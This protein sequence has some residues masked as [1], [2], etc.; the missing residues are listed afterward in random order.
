MNE[1][2]HF[3]IGCNERCAPEDTLCPRCEAALEI[4]DAQTTPQARL[5]PGGTI[6]GS[7]QRGTEQD[8][9]LIGS[10]LGVYE[11][12]DFLGRG[13]MA[14]VYLAK[15]SMLERPCALKLLNP[16]LVGADRQFVSQ[17]FSEARAA[18]ALVHPNVVTIHNIGEGNGYHFI[19][20]EYVPGV[21]LQ[22]KLRGRGRLEPLRATE[23]MVQ[24][25]AGLAGAHRSGIVHRDLKP[26][27][28][29]VDQTGRA[30][31]ADFGLAKRVVGGNENK[32]SGKLAGTP[33]FMA[34]E[35][36]TGTEASRMADVYAAGVTYY[37]L[38]TGRMPF[39][40][41]SLVELARQHAER[42]PPD[43]SELQP[44]VPEQAV[45]VIRRCLAKDPLDR[46][47]DAQDLHDDLRA[48]FGTLRALESLL[49]EA[50]AD[51]DWPWNPDGDGFVVTVPLQ[52]G[53]SQRVYIEQD[54]GGN[55]KDELVKIYSPCAP[56]QSDFAERALALNAHIPHA[57]I[58]VQ[59]HH[60]KMYYVMM[61][62]YPR[63]T[64]DPEEVRVATRTIAYW[65]DYIEHTLTGEDVH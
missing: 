52:G 62:A 37:Y 10:E 43:I 18:A 23:L 24:T 3:C 34:P 20:M 49:H 38:L 64:C 9:E 48:V 27:N 25:C 54:R 41:R 50:Y 61:A 55:L 2:V 4:G 44:D 21:S 60:G 22:R 11:I 33:Y 42:P 36:F 28:I 39:F 16:S 45:E 17:F 53:R 65:S 58:A 14:R 19:E 47:A 5:T 13:G 30:K 7:S 63:S 31:L 46:Y 29:L 51:L 8:R 6:Q 59:P 57:S 1:T 40:T 32:N 35:L 15:H 56:F 26:A 12:Q